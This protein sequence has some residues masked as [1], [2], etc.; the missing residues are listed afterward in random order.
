MNAFFKELFEYNHCSNQKL[1]DVLL[2]R[3]NKVTDKFIK[4]QSH[5]INAHQVWNSRLIKYEPFGVWE[6]HPLSELKKLDT[7]NHL[8]TLEVLNKMELPQIIE[9]KNIKGQPFSNSVR[10][11]LFH[12]INHSTYHRGQIASDCKQNRIEPIV[13]DYIAYKR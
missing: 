11:I 5:I 1:I 8:K 2:E 9:Y 10:D 12:M 13:T 4:L 7:A 3:E 6:I